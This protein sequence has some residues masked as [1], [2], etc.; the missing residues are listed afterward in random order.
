MRAHIDILILFL[1]NC[2]PLQTSQD[3][4]ALLVDTLPEQTSEGGALSL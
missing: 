1:G 4:Q 2:L 3:L